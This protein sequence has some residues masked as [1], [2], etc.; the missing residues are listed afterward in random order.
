MA[1]VVV[2]LGGDPRHRNTEGMTVRVSFLARGDET[3]EEQPA[4]SLQEEYPHISLYLRSL[5]GEAAPASEDPSP[6]L[7]TPTDSLLHVVRSIMEASER[8]ELS[9]E[10]T[11]ER[12]REVVERAVKGQVEVGREIGMEEGGE[13]EGRGR[14]REED[15]NGDERM[16]GKRRR[17]EPGR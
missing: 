12:L 11:D 6:D 16:E 14:E 5:T 3:D 8:G 15:M 17:E 9:A 10:E 13:E 4:E 2:E 7:D 1:R